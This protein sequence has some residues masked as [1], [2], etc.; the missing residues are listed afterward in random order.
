MAAGHITWPIGAKIWLWME[1]GRGPED[2]A[3]DYGER[4]GESSKSGVTGVDGVSA[5]AKLARG[6]GG[7]GGGGGEA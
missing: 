3:R 2:G 4:R 5:H 1:G 6:K 7:D